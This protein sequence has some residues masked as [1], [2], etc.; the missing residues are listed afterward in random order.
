MKYAYLK[1]N[2]NPFRGLKLCLKTTVTTTT[3]SKLPFFRFTEPTVS[4]NLYI[5]S[6]S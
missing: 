1:N 3:T 5:T 4:G 6:E 2:Q